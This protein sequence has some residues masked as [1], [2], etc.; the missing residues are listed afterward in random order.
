MTAETVLYDNLVR[1]PSRPNN[2]GL[3][4]QGKDS[5]MIE[6]IGC[7][8]IVF[9]Y[10]AVLG[11]MAIIASCPDEMGAI[12][13]GLVIGTHDMAIDAGGRFVGHIGK[14]TRNVKNVYQ[15]AS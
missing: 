8:E 7:F 10:E 11:Q 6:A 2:L 15:S 13:P 4:V 1:A 14:D 5:S 12:L 3:H 9:V